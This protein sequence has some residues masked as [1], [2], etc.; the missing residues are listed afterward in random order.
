[1]PW[2][3]HTWA[4]KFSY[5]IQEPTPR[6]EIAIPDEP[7]TY[8]CFIN[9]FRYNLSLNPRW[10]PY[11]FH[12]WMEILRRTNNT[13]LSM[14]YQLSLTCLVL[15]Y[16]NFNSEHKD[17]VIDWMATHYSDINPGRLLWLPGT[18]A[19][20]ISWKAGACNVALDVRPRGRGG[21]FNL[22]KVVKRVDLGLE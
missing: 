15:K 13:A 22:E 17:Y 18:G 5:G 6:R 9:N 16:F 3:Y 8:C 11:D 4:H 1:M 20:H 12:T 14:R 2:S 21:E 19:K 10:T 7:F